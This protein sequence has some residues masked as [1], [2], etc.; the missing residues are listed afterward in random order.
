MVA[1]QEEANTGTVDVRSR[2]G[3]RVGKMRVDEVA[4]FFHSQQPPKSK[5]FEELYSKMWKPEDFNNQNQN[6]QN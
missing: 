2:D 1:G 3:E 4:K 6:Q 5:S